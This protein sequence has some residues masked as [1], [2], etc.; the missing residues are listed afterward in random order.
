M[1]GEDDRVAGGHHRDSVVDDRGARVGRGCDCADYPPRRELGQGEAVV[2][3]ED[4]GMEI[5]GSGR[6]VDAE[7]ILESLVAHVAEPGLAY[8][9]LRQR[10]RGFMQP[11][12]LVCD[13]LVA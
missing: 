4:L 9:L 7:L 5:L 12:A 1:S 8:S 6:L 3:R 2:A 10:P 13:D 11:L